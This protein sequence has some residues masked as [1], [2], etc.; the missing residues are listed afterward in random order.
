MAEQEVDGNKE[1]NSCLLNLL[2]SPSHRQSLILIEKTRKYDIYYFPCPISSLGKI[3]L[4]VL[5]KELPT[6]NDLQKMNN[7]LKV[8]KKI[9]HPAF[10]KFIAKTTY[11]NKPALLLEWAEGEPIGRVRKFDV[12]R[13]FLLIS[14]EIVSTLVAMHSSNVMHMRLSCEH[15]I[16]DSNSNS[17]KIIGSSS[18]SSFSSE[19]AHVSYL[20][21]L[22]IEVECISPEQADRFN[23]M[24]DLRSDFYSLGVIFYKMLIGNFPPE[25]SN[26]HQILKMHIF[27]KCV[28][29]HYI[30]Q[31]IAVPISDMVSKL[32]EIN[33]EKRYQS[34]KGILYDL[35]LMISEYETDETLASVTLGTYDTL[36][37]LLIPRKLY[38]C[39]L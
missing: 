25:N 6:T 30:D 33:P 38:D 20:G 24:I 23:K 29:I 8:S 14:R 28:A 15:I 7:E 9:F 2:D 4:K 37:V 10:R 36:E 12:L 1:E 34:A 11:E 27:H 31:T 3:A 32:M 19:S 22:D 18:S 17:V 13:N 39:E 5:R 16:F 21:D 35:E 26:K